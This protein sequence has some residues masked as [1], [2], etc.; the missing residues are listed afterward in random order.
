MLL[1]LTFAA[2]A[3]TPAPLATFAA[4]AGDKPATLSGPAFPLNAPS[5]PSS[6]GA[7]YRFTAPPSNLEDLVDVVDEHDPEKVVGRLANAWSVDEG[8]GLVSATARL[9]A[10]TRGRDLAVEVAEG[11]KTGFSVA[12]AFDSYVEDAEGVREVSDWTAAHLGVVRNPAFTQSRGLSLAASAHKEGTAPM[13][14]TAL[15]AAPEGAGVV[16]LPTTAE[17]AAEVAKV[18]EAG[19]S[20]TGAHPLAQFSSATQFWAAFQSGTEEDRARLRA[21]FALVDQKIA[22][23]PALAVPQ[24]RERI[25]QNLDARRPAIRALGGSIGLPDSGMEV[26]WPKFDGDLDALVAE[27]TVELEELTSVLVKITSGKGTIKTAGAASRI[28]YQALLRTSP[29]YRSA[30]QAIMDAAWARYTEARF[31]GAL[32]AGATVAGTLPAIPSGATGAANFAAL[33]F[34]LS[35]QVE[36]ATGKPATAVLVGSDV[37]KELGATGLVNPA[38][39]TQNVS[40]T[41][42]AA[43]LSVNV[44][45]LEVTRAPFF[46]AG[47]SIVTNDE[48][49]KFSESGPMLATEE[50]VAHLGQN[51]ATWGMYVPAEIYFPAG[52]LKVDRDAG[53]LPN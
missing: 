20:T 33:L 52:V 13:P 31:E 11:V 38:Y 23:N 7:R 17:L 28:S 32:V 42:S 26:N 50:D 49:A 2:P 18:L 40:G 44:N 3:G 6:D 10:T 19:K 14:Q 34:D 29:A 46:P 45:G 22:D 35:A 15:P 21:D 53:T 16:D 24:W 48:A 47:T 27:Q 4:A 51:V 37:W 25:I 5:N 9:F 1:A 12:A 43:T 8:A 36:D 39:G 41:A 30:Y